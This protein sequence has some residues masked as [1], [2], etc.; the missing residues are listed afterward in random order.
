MLIL[1]S[2]LPILRCPASGEP[3]HLIKNGLRAAE[4]SYIFTHGF[5]DLVAAKQVASL[6][7]LFQKQY[8]EK[9]AQIYDTLLKVQSCLFGCWEP[10]ERRRLAR[11]LGPPRGGLI[12]EVAVGTGANLTHLAAAAGPEST[13]VGVDL[14]LAMLQRAKRRAAKHRSRQPRTCLIRADAC[15]LPFAADSFDAVFHFGGINMFG[16]IEQALAEMVRVAKPGAPILVGDEGMS[17]KRR[18]TWVGRRLGKLNTLNLCRPPFALVPW[19]NI[20]H[21]QLHWAWRELFYVFVLRKGRIA[22]AGTELTAHQ[23]IRR[24][25]GT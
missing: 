20:H 2:L 11:L 1:E 16:S 19:D 17:E 4:Q 6:D 14:S 12:L 3:L 7:T 24:R 15:H 21:F 25:T 8:D 18:R 23:E 5:A 10:A 22:A 13:L 9:T